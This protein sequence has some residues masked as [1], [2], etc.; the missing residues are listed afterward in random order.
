MDVMLEYYILSSAL[1]IASTAADTQ[2]TTTRN[3]VVE[4][5]AILQVQ[6]LV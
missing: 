6:G 1:F 2:S 5:L 3:E 4:V